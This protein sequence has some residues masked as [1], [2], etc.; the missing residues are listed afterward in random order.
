[1]YGFLESATWHAGPMIDSQETQSSAWLE[2]A[3]KCKWHA[4]LGPH[5][6][7]DVTQIESSPKQ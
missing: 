1:M 4:A 7:S 3:A 2:L 5:I 6:N